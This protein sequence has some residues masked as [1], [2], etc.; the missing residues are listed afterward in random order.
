MVVF[1]TAGAVYADNVAT[2]ARHPPLCRVTA[3][4]ASPDADHRNGNIAGPPGSSVQQLAGATIAM[5]HNP[6]TELKQGYSI[7]D[8]HVVRAW[9]QN[10]TVNR[11]E[12]Q[13]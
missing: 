9:L 3:P 12:R 13:T 4:G 8:V 10:L 2:E 7:Q 11:Q 6:F 1:S 5:R